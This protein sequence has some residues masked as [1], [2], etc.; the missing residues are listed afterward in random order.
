MSTHFVT[1]LPPTPAMILAPAPA[2]AP[3]EH[4]VLHPQ[5]FPRPNPNPNSN[6]NPNPDHDA[7]GACCLL[8]QP[9]RITPLDLP[10]LLILIGQYLSQ[11]EA[12]VCVLVCRAWR[13]AFE[14]VLWSHVETANCIPIADMERHATEIRTL[15]L[16]DL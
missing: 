16:T 10:E 11:R 3:L 5:P 4:H 1:S 9:R 12:L 7:H 8:Q 13:I 2:T 14:P 15:S 6:P